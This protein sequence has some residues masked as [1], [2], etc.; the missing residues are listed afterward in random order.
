MDPDTVDVVQN[1]SKTLD[2]NNIYDIMIRVNQSIKENIRV[3]QSI[4][5][6]PI[7]YIG[8]DYFKN[9]IKLISDE[10]IIDFLN[11]Y[12]LEQTRIDLLLICRS[13][14]II[15]NPR[16]EKYLKNKNML[17]NALITYIQKSKI[18]IPSAIHG[19]TVIQ[20]VCHLT[21]DC[22][23]SI[24]QSLV[25]ENGASLNNIDFRGRNMLDLLFMNKVVD[26]HLTC[27]IINNWDIKL[28]EDNINRFNKYLDKCKN[29]DKDETGEYEIITW[30]R[31]NYSIS[32]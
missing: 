9:N 1:G 23:L 12:Y 8:S 16:Y 27:Y 7:S 13:Y 10:D 30:I 32:E 15:M 2:E 25:N 20:R 26:Y 29:V 22:N 28:T 21:N 24:I 11:N 6:K 17:I 31:D 18:N 4:K 14:K 3:N 5:E 19:Q